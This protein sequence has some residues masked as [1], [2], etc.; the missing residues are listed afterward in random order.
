MN[1]VERLDGSAHLFD[2]ISELIDQTRTTVA[3]QTNAA[4]TLT[5]WQI[6]YLINTEVLAEQR[7][8]YAHEIV[9]TLSRQLTTRY[10]RGFD[11]A[12]LY[13]M[14]Q[15][16][17]VFPDRDRVA[18]LSR[19][20]SWSHFITLIAVGSDTARDFYIQQTLDARLSVRALR[21]L[22]GRQGFER[23]EIANAQTPG[24]SAVPLDTFSDPYFLDFLGLEDAYAERDL[25][26]ALVR[27]MEAF[28]L[29]VGN[30]WT[31]VARQKRMTV[32]N[33][34]FAL[35]LLF[36]S[37]PLHR[38]IAV[39]LKVGKFKPA[40]EG[41]MKLYL[42]WLD[43]YERRSDEEPPLGLILCTETSR[44]QIELLEMHKDGIVVAEYWTALPPREELQQRIAQIYRDA[45]ERIARRALNPADIDL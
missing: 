18:T 14:R 21:E 45:R 34:D 22:I 11:R 4:L 30:G 31:F 23:R 26:D 20:V 10:G 1:T 19:H 42:K 8:E 25:E 3:V 36:Y 37:R 39:E 12:N 29:E 33:D 44:E 17:Q 24:G 32:G 43:R 2:R 28:L 7:A 41:Q 35:D 6:G 38:L 5:N 16:V 9:V 15:F 27:D 13:R 40:H